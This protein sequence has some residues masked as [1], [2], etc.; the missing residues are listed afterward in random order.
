MKNCTS[1][2]CCNCLK[3]VPVCLSDLLLIIPDYEFLSEHATLEFVR[4]VG[5]FFVQ[6]YQFQIQGKFKLKFPH[7]EIW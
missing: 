2:R 6:M 1:L 5:L 7:F 4:D 3:F